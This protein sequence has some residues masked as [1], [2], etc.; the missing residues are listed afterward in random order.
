MAA[1]DFGAL[2]D[3]QKKVWATEIWIA[4]RDQSFWFS[5]GFVGKGD[6]DISRPIQ[7]ITQLTPTERG[8]EC[9]MQLVLDMQS[10]GVVGDNP[11]TNNEEALTNDAQTIRIDQLR[12]GV[13]NKGEMA[14]QATVIRF[15]STAKD[16]LTFW[17]SDKIDELAFLTAAGRAYTLNTNGSTR[18]TSQLP[19][20][21]FAAD[22]AAASSGRIIYA[23]TATSEATLTTAMTMNW[24]FLVSCK[25]M[26]QRKKIKPIR[27][28]GKE[29]WAVVMSTEQER[30]LL[31]DSTYQTIVRSAQERGHNNPLFSNSMAVVQ[32]LILYSHNKVFNTLGATTKWGAGS[33][34]DGAQALLLGSQALGFATIGD[35]FWREADVNDYGNAPGIGYGRK[36]GMLKP[37]FKSLTDSLTA[38][39]FGIIS[40]KTAAAA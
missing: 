23:S 7:R 22:V 35:S 4:G 14:E 6:G 30:D 40:A 39:D 5:N 9:V 18:G 26:A 17:L 36:F 32:G 37:Q 16:K 25:A 29:Y 28:G 38:Q 1:T 12:N 34:V 19:S 27:Q 21:K 2:T 3:A 24:N 11:L 15:R 8:T 31:Q 10:D 20:L 33:N 13:K